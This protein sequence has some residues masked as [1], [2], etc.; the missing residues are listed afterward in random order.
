MRRPPKYDVVFYPPRLT[1][2]PG[3]G[4]E[5]TIGGAQT[6]VILRAQALA[7]L[8]VRVCI[9]V[10]GDEGDAQA[11]SVQGVDIV[12]RS[13]SV[14]HQRL[15]GKVREFVRIWRALRRADAEVVVVDV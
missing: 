6:Q 5:S 14:A 9:L 4:L 13:E 10:P 3:T 2:S 12:L 11:L 8:G 1:P 7:R 15:V